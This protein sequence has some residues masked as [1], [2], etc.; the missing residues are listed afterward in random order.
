MYKYTLQ[1]H[2]LHTPLLFPDIYILIVLMF[3]YFYSHY[4]KT[5]SL[6]SLKV[7]ITLWD[8]LYL[9]ITI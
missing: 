1:H 9:Q 7:Q 6:A 2:D 3:L 5:E 8:S 4:T